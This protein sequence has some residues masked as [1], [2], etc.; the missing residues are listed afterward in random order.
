MGVAAISAVFRY[1]KST[2]N[3]RNVLAVMADRADD[4]GLCWPGV[5]DCAARA[6]CSVRTV[7][8]ALRDLE[9]LGELK[10]LA[11]PE[12]GRKK[13]P[14][15]HL[16]LPTLD[17]VI[18]D[19]HPY[20]ERHKGAIS[21]PFTRERKGARSGS[22]RV[23]A[24]AP[25]PSVKEPSIETDRPLTPEGESS[26]DQR[27]R[28][29]AEQGSQRKR[30]LQALAAFDASVYPGVSRTAV[31]SARHILRRRGAEVTP[32]AIRAEMEARGWLPET[33]S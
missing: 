13:T 8:Y 7:Q 20:L 5:E 21:A 31:A 23:Q 11:S 4:H 33:T 10:I 24:S 30:D 12:G 6:N 14:L 28:E 26:L 16:D 25:E 2:G 9:A 27:R 17:G 15:Y 29:R 22:K 19:D 3:T 1:S 32:E 18:S